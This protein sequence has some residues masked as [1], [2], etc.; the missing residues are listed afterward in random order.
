MV[1]IRQWCW[2]L[3]IHWEMFHSPFFQ[4]QKS[5]FNEGF[6]TSWIQ[7]LPPSCTVTLFVHSFLFSPFLPT[8][9]L[10]ASGLFPSLPRKCS[11]DSTVPSWRKPVSLSWSVSVVAEM[12][13]SGPRLGREPAAS[14]GSGICPG[15]ISDSATTAAVEREKRGRETELSTR[16]QRPSVK[17]QCCFY[18]ADRGK[19]SVLK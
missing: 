14:E 18:R 9:V 15:I 11:G 17:S 2:P 19:Q 4:N 12:P 1:Y 16:E 7:Y 13:A 8:S 3:I 6:E 10:I 5:C